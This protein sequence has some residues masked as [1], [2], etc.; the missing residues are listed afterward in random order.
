MNRTN[1]RVY[2]VDGLSLE[3]VDSIDYSEAI[4]STTL[5]TQFAVRIVMHLLLD[6]TLDNAVA[7]GFID[8]A[9]NL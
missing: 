1:Q 5:S 6:D 7:V 9:K 2:T 4:V 3:P 8:S